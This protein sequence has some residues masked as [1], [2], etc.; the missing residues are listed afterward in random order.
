MDNNLP[1]PSG[2]A[3]S[4]CGPSLRE[5]PPVPG[6]CHDAPAFPISVA[7]F[8]LSEVYARYT[9]AHVIPDADKAA[10]YKARYLAA[11]KRGTRPYRAPAPS[12]K[13]RAVAALGE[14]E[15]QKTL[16]ATFTAPELKPLA[17]PSAPPWADH[18]ARSSEE[19]S[20]EGPMPYSK[21]L[22]ASGTTE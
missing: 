1:L 22:P 12:R 3:G 15:P 14:P 10:Y 18:P 20:V 13:P 21:P 19:S 8:S 11:Q 5:G 9:S 17:L 7:L 4:S 16:E 6:L 2:Y